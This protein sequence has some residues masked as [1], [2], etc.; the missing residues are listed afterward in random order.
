[1]PNAF[2]LPDKQE[3]NTCMQNYSAMCLDILDAQLTTVAG[4]EKYQSVGNMQF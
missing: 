3:M 2:I 4:N 1:M